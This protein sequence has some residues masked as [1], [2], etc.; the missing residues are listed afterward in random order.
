M[1]QTA[2]IFKVNFYTPN[3]AKLQNFILL[4]QSIIKEILKFDFAAKSFS[5]ISSTK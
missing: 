1:F 4:F 5:S 2:K 3:Y